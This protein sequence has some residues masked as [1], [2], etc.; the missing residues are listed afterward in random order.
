MARV[1]SDIS[2]EPIASMIRVS[3]I[4]EL[5]KTLLIIGNCSM[6]EVLLR[7]ALRLL[8]T[9]NVF[10]TSIILYTL[11]KETIG[12]SETSVITSATRRHIPE[13]GIL[14]SYRRENLRSYMIGYKLRVV[15]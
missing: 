5:E 10:L 11:M 1:R 7:S 9:A 15:R 3:R 8:V 4:N 2:E 13:Y 12:S 14:H 6:L